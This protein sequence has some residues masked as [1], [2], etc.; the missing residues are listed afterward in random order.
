MTTNLHNEYLDSDAQNT[1]IQTSLQNVLESG[2]DSQ[3]E[4]DCSCGRIQVNMALD[5]LHNVL[6]GVINQ[7]DSLNFGTSENVDQNHDSEEQKKEF[8]ESESQSE[9]NKIRLNKDHKV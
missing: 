7:M 6:D 8:S 1:D 5:I 9:E 4:M 3:V 2:M